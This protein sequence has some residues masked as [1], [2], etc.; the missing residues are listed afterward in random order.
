MCFDNRLAHFNSPP[1]HRRLGTYL[2]HVRLWQKAPKTNWWL[3]LASRRRC[4]APR[5]KALR[6]PPQIHRR[7]VQNRSRIASG[8]YALVLCIHLNQV[9]RQYFWHYRSW[10]LVAMVLCV[11]LL[12]AASCCLAVRAQEMVRQGLRQ[13]GLGYQVNYSIGLGSQGQ[14]GETIGY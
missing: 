9:V 12:V 10:F 8:G 3:L 7:K 11:L 1:S 5:G 4:R 2:Q 6:R 13:I 14:K